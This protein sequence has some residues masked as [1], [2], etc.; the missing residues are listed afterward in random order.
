MALLNFIS[1]FAEAEATVKS[2]CFSNLLFNAHCFSVVKCVVL[3]RM[4][5]A[6]CDEQLHVHV[7]ICVCVPECVC[8][9]SGSWG[10]LP[11]Y[12]QNIKDAFSKLLSF[13]TSVRVWVF[14][15]LYSSCRLEFFNLL[16]ARFF[17]LWRQFVTFLRNNNKQPKI[18]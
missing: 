15:I 7:R 5:E 8:V 1:S 3:F 10:M 6:N 17:F 2:W 18:G 13:L 12:N 9:F 11:A 4:S 16:A 14:S